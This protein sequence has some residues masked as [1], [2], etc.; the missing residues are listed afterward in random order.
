MGNEVTKDLTNRGFGARMCCTTA[1]AVVQKLMLI[2]ERKQKKVLVV[3]GC[4][5]KCASRVI[6]S[7]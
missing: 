3:N 2:L 6:P 7:I 1:V 5:N 4:A